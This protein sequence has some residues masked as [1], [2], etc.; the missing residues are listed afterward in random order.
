MR[1]DATTAD[2][3]AILALNEAFVSVLSPLDHEHLARLHAQAARHRV[4]E[5]DGRVVAFVLVLREG[6]DY[7]SPNYQWF[8]QR[9]VRFLY[10]DRIVVA[11]DARGAG[12]RLYRDAFEF[13][14]RDAVPVI[15]CEF[16]IQ[17]PNPAS[18][19]FHARL[20]FHE[21]GQQPLYG[22]SKVVSLQLLDVAA[23]ESPLARPSAA[24]R[25]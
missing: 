9:H 2:F 8:A 11:A 13:A 17:P 23:G 19:R 25:P 5:Q 3:P 16:D 1:R 10:V 21:V 4:I 12:T 7:D 22:G 15:T 14:R 20:G 18:E 6:A 24:D